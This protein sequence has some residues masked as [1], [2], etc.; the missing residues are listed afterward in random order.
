MVEQAKI[1]LI[2]DDASSRH[3][4]E[5]IIEFLGEEVIS[6]NSDGW[7]SAA[8]SFIQDSTQVV[9]TVI[10]RCESIPLEELVQELSEWEPS[11]PS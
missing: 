8:L 7:H 3:D 11:M 1:L 9:A 6:A 2:D 5:T 10:G 4:L